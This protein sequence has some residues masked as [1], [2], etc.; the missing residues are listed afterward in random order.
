MCE[1]EKRFFSIFFLLGAKILVHR[2]IEPKTKTT[3]SEVLSRSN[4]K[5]FVIVRTRK[6]AHAPLD[7]EKQCARLPRF[8]YA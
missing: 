8:T 2:E 4:C 5:H 7:I 3:R 6:V 1:P